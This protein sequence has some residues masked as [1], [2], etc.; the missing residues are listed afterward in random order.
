G[1]PIRRRRGR[2]HGLGWSPGFQDGGALSPLGKRRCPAEDEPNRLFGRAERIGWSDRS[3][4][5]TLRRKGR[6]QRPNRARNGKNPPNS[7]AEFVPLIVPMDGTNKNAFRNSLF[8]QG[9]RKAD[10]LMRRGGD[11]NPRYLAVHRFS[12]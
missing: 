6:S 9:L 10:K 4:V 5:L 3:S 1:I 12:R 2:D 11:S 8:S 7:V